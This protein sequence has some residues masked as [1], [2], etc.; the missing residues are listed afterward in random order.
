MVKKLSIVGGL[1]VGTIM[2]AA[3][4][5]RQK[6][7]KP[8]PPE[9]F[10]PKSGS[11]PGAMPGDNI[12][13]TV[14]MGESNFPEVTWTGK[15]YDITWWDLRNPS[16]TVYSVGMDRQGYE[17]RPLRRISQK[18][19]SKQ[20]S[21]KSDGKETHIVWQ[22]DGKIY[23]LRL[24]G[25]PEPML[26]SSRGT[27]P[28]A[29]PWGAAAYVEEGILYFRCDG[30]IDLKTGEPLPPAPVASGGIENPRIA[31]N[32][33]YFALVW[34]ESAAGGRQIMMQ[35][36]S[37]EGEKLGGK[38]KV[39]AVAGQSRKPAIAWAGKNFAVAWTNAA[40]ADDNPRDRYRIFMA[41]VPPVGDRPLSTR[42][43]KFS[44]SADQVALAAT[45]E[46]FGLAWVGS[47]DNG[48]SAVYLQRL[49]LQGELL[50]ETVEVTDGVP[51]VCSNPS[52]TWDGKGYAVVWHDDRGQVDTEI[53][54]SLIACGDAPLES[55]PKTEEKT[56][57]TETAPE[58]DGL[59]GLK[60]AF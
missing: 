23:S 18:G 59:P 8:T 53:Y 60:E 24:E 39:S 51:F 17:V 55:E 42:Q 26:L 34:S 40:P 30:M 6:I 36:V 54:M 33:V 25:D 45:G 38:V 43:L 9:P 21:V 14:A 27:D 16:P 11:C 44:G 56:D 20:H 47:R 4:G 32:G 57:S 35:R 48:G 1:L 31:Y 46:E 19:S 12:Q 10:L 22:E 41:M 49:S 28:A 7:P 3:C 13:V 52:L 15:R 29:G 50:E 2:L 58:S 37:P 5:G